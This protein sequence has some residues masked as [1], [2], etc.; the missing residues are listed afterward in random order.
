MLSSTSPSEGQISQEETSTP[1]SIRSGSGSSSWTMTQ[2][3]I[4]AMDL[5]PLSA[6]RSWQIPSWESLQGR[7]DRESSY[8]TIFSQTRD[9]SVH[10]RLDS[11]ELSEQS[12]PSHQGSVQS[13]PSNSQRG[14][15]A[16]QE[17]SPH[18]CSH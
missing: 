7:S 10:P 18:A 2:Q 16:R 3:S 1:S 5:R 17:S 4:Q 8:P 12:Q 14:Y 6:M 13:E 11:E 15:R 9:S